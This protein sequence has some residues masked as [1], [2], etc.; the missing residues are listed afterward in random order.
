MLLQPL[1]NS[2]QR[3]RDFPRRA[4][5]GKCSKIDSI[6]YGIEMSNFRPI[7]K[8]QNQIE[9]FSITQDDRPYNVEFSIPKK[10]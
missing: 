7:K 1:Q 3:P 2:L 9:T 4:D 5:Q 6:N 10:E 8:L